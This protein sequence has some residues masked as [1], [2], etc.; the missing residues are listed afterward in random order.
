MDT[1]LF[2]DDWDAF[3]GGNFAITSDEC[4]V[5]FPMNKRLNE[6]NLETNKTTPL[7]FKFE[8]FCT[9]SFDKT[10][11]LWITDSKHKGGTLFKW[12]KR[13][14]FKEFVTHFFP[15]DRSNALF[16]EPNHHLFYGI[17]FSETGNPLLTE[18]VEN[19]IWEISE[20]GEKS[21]RYTSDS[22]WS[23]TGVYYRNEQYYVLEFGYTTQNNGPRL[24][25]L[26][27]HFKKTELFEFDFE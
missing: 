8:R 15:N 6:R 18:N 22:T 3:F 1:L 4:K 13:N 25:I 7:K 23:P 11:T 24:V 12:D 10:E 14:G 2:T 16:K 9:M 19:S 17:G 26:D 21:L 5:Y 27:K 20:D